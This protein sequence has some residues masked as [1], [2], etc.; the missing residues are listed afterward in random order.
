MRLRPSLTVTTILLAALLLAILPAWLVGRNDLS[1]AGQAVR[2][3]DYARAAD[4]MEA[5]ARLLFWRSDLWEQAAGYAL[6]AGDA[7]HAAALLD[8]ASSRFRLTPGGFRTLGDARFQAGDQ[9][10]ALRAWDQA[11]GAGGPDASIFERQANLRHLR[12]EY[13]QESAILDSWLK[14]DPANPA[15]RLRRAVLL[16]AKDPVQALD[17]LYAAQGLPPGREQ[18]FR[19]LRTLLT[20]ASLEQ[21]PAYRLMLAGQ[22]LAAQGDWPLARQAFEG[23]VDQSPAYAEGWAWLAEA[24]QQ[25]GR[26]GSPALRRALALDASL[27]IVQAFTGMYQMR[28]GRPDLALTRFAAAAAGEPSNPAWQAALG[29]AYARQGN[30]PPALAAYRRAT[31]LA[32][33]E[34]RYWRLLAS[35]C[36]QYGIEI[37]TTAYA[38]AHTAVQLDRDDPLALD[39]LGWLFLAI[40]RPLEA[41]PPL[42]QAN[43]MSPGNALINLHLGIAQLQAGQAG[44]AREHLQNAVRL[45]PQGQAGWQAGLLLEQYFK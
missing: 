15:A 19:A 43:Q 11:L 5:A 21:D 30:L 23:A 3:G 18:T 31:A 29:D 44:A 27:P 37:D 39:T 6:Q 28:Q 24:Q 25:T 2:I 13:S 7:P 9:E 33:G 4:A 12:G 16:A 45:D 20:R 22:W 41:I 1:R 38:S 34:S 42:Q 32:P 14:L 17:E 40:G 26:D 10:S 35:F 8:E 36:I